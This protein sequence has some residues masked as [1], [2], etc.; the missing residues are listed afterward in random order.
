MATGQCHFSTM[1]TV[2]VL[3]ASSS[4]R[5]RSHLRRSSRYRQRRLI[6]ATSI[7]PT[8]LESEPYTDSRQPVE[9]VA[10]CLALYIERFHS[11]ERDVQ[12]RT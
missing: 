2:S 10:D 12:S 11:D 9:L 4:N 8:K 6:A 1:S 3:R 5:C 7:S